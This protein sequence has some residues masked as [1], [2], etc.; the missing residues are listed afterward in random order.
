MILDLV[1]S[2]ILRYLVD[3]GRVAVQHVAD[4]ASLSQSTCS[5]RIQSLEAQGIISG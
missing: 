4:Y 3:H 1:D 5:R 2:R